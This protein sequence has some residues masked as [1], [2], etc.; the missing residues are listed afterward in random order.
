MERGVTPEK[1]DGHGLDLGRA[2]RPVPGI[3]IFNTQFHRNNHSLKA[4]PQG[5]FLR[6][7]GLAP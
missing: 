5:N 4:V 2:S 6:S 1:E 7:S 3:G